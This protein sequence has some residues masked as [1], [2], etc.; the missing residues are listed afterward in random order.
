MTLA[1]KVGAKNEWPQWCKDS[2]R[3]FFL[4]KVRSKSG[5]FILS[6]SPK[7]YCVNC[8]DKDSLPHYPIK[9]PIKE[10]ALR[11]KK[12]LSN[13]ELCLVDLEVMLNGETRSAPTLCVTDGQE[14]I[15]LNTPDS[16]PIQMNKANAIKF[17]DG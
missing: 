14:M 5:N 3:A 9:K 11:V 4:K 8:F 16:R 6:K 1:Q 15:P 2:E 7:L 17:S 10:A 12:I 13:Y